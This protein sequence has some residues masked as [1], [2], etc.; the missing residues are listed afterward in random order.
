MRPRA[1]C[2]GARVLAGVPTMLEIDT[3]AITKERGSWP[4]KNSTTSFSKAAV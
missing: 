1:I 2:D 4:A 3:D